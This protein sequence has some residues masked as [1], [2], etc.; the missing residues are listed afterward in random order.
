[1]ETLQTQTVSPPADET[2]YAIEIID[3]GQG[4]VSDPTLGIEPVAEQSRKFSLT[5]TNQR[6]QECQWRNTDKSLPTHIHRAIEF[7]GYHVTDVSSQPK[8]GLYEHISY[9]H[10][11]TTGIEDDL[12][13]EDTLSRAA[14]GWARE[15]L[16]LLTKLEILQ[17]HLSESE[18]AIVLMKAQLTTNGNFSGNMSVP[19]GEREQTDASLRSLVVLMLAYAQHDG[20]LPQTILDP[21]IVSQL[22]MEVSHA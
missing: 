20:Y 11:S 10:E 1:M 15:S 13:Q 12:H 5:V 22:V 19:L 8:H 3:Y 9:L 7:Y 21:E 2:E 14:L 18:Y 6:L 16:E 4:G 17:A